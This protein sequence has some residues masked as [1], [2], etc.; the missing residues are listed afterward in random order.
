MNNLVNNREKS[1][2]HM[3]I[4]NIIWGYGNTFLT[5]VLKFVCRWIFIRTIGVTYL[6]INGLYTNIL[7]VLSLSELGIATAM[8]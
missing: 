7:Q 4:K 2:T 1:R 8:N 5:T 6:G 3:A